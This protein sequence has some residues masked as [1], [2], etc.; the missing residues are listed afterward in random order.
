MNA[1]QLE[2]KN[3]RRTSSPVASFLLFILVLVLT[4]GCA[5]VRGTMGEEFEAKDIAKLHKGTS[6]RSEVGVWLGAPDEIVQ[7]GGYEIFHYRQ[8][9]SKMGYL[10]FLSRIN[11]GSSNLYVFFDQHGIVREVI[12][13]EQTKDLE[14]QIWPFGD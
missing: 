4:P 9:D 7:A 11:V 8:Y 2:F 1:T 14:F 5:F 12:Y 10:M 3:N 6:T 13:G